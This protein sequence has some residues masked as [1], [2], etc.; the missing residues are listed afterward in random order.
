GVSKVNS[1]IDFSVLEGCLREDLDAAAARRMAVIEPLQLV[2]T[3]LDEGHVESLAFP[4]HPKDESFGTRQVPY[5]NRLWIEQDDFAEV[6]PKGFKRLVPGGE[7]RLR[8]AGIVRCDDVIKDAAG[9]VTEL[10]CT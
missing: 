6:P 2:I 10:R 9:N 1:V 8:G 7:V 4:N 3:D 5:S